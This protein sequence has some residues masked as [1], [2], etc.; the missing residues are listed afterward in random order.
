MYVYVYSVDVTTRI[1]IC[2]YTYI[3]YIEG[4][5]SSLPRCEIIMFARYLLAGCCARGPVIPVHEQPD[6]TPTVI[7][8][9]PARRLYASSSHTHRAGIQPVSHNHPLVCWPG[10]NSSCVRVY[11]EP[12]LNYVGTFLFCYYL[13]VW[14]SDG[15]FAT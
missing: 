14:K 8:H 13:S 2:R 15:Y 12:M 10:T 6:V 4:V 5:Y 7:V 11:D 1:I 9:P 3:V